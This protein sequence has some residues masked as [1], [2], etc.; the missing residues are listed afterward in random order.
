MKKLFFIFLI[1][2]LSLNFAVTADEGAGVSLG[3]E[4]GI[5]NINHK[6]DWTPYIMP[7]F[8]FD[9]T[10]N[11]GAL[12]IFAELDYTFGFEKVP[13]DKDDV[14]PQ[15]V[16][17]DLLFGYNK[18][19]GAASTLSFILENEF[20]EYIISPRPKANKGS[21]F[22]GILTP[23]VIYTQGFDFGDIYGGVGIPITYMQYMQEF[24]DTDLVLGANF[25]VGWNSVFGLGLEAKAFA[26]LSPSEGRGYLGLEALASYENGPMY[27]EV[28]AQIPKEIKYGGITITPEFDFSFGNVTFYAYSELAGIGAEGGSII[29]S[30]A[31]GVKF[32]F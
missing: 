30:P 16:Y 1:L 14:Y 19:V 9:H 27:F 26:Q 24:K 28:L 6:D 13:E 15:S 25:T 11:D 3:L 4:V 12:D 29:I 21:D 32:N 18:S 2:L 5:G 20:D 22:T 10:F 23:A 31:I 7:M 8:I 17:F